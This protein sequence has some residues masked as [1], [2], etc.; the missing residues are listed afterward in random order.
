MKSLRKLEENRDE[1]KMDVEGTEVRVVHG[2]GCSCIEFCG[3]ES[4]E[5]VDAGAF[6]IASNRLLAGSGSVDSEQDSF[7]RIPWTPESVHTLAGTN[8]GTLGTDDTRGAGEVPGRHKRPLRS[9]WIAN[10]RVEGLT[11]E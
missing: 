10:G 5:L 7:W 1:K 4:L 2:T 11:C 9:V 8:D 6:W 3:D